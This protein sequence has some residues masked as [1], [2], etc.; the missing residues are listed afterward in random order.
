MAFA[1]FWVARELELDTEELLGFLGASALLVGLMA[2]LGL[3]GAA[4]VLIV[5]RFR[6]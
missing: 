2:V 4:A 5:K 1:L 3:A 6:R